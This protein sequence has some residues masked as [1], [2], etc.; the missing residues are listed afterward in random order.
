MP[1]P[2]SA[3]KERDAGKV[4]GPIVGFM[5]LACAGVAGLYFV[6]R[7][8]YQLAALMLRTGR[9]MKIGKEL[10]IEWFYGSFDLR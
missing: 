1:L 4:P 3:K 7:K 8:L 5:I 6:D 10:A 2:S 9:G